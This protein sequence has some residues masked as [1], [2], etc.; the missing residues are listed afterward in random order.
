MDGGASE[1]WIRNSA[2]QLAEILPDARHV[3]LEG[4]DHGPD[5]D[6]LALMLVEFF[7]D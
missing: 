2:K 7:A 5:D 4:Q 6:A 3:T 1:S